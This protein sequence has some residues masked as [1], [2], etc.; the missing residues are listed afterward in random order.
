MLT[1]HRNIQRAKVYSEGKISELRVALLGI[2]LPSGVTIVSVGSVARR[3]ASEQSDLDYFVITESDDDSSDAWEKVGGLITAL[4]LRAPSPTGAFAKSVSTKKFLEAIGGGDESNEELTRRMLFLLESEWLFGEATYESL[5]D[6]VI[7]CY[8]K[9]KITQH[10][11]ARFFLNDLIRYYRTICVDFEYKTV[12]GGKSW[13]DRNIKLM[14]ARKL[15][16]FSGVISAAETVQSNCG[17]KRRELKRLL[18]KTP[19]E[20]VLDVCGSDAERALKRYDEFLGWLADGTAR[21]LL[22]GTTAN[23]ETHTNEFREMKNSGHHF[24]WELESLL[25]RRYAAT[26]PIYQA[27]LL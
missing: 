7:E 3:E 9:D 18:R 16:Y 27:I 2:G 10:Q 21:E 14:F 23:R 26:H 4:G 13:G 19:L 8:I 15:L 20:R 17:F 24:S 6:K 12:T 25:H 5:V 1:E 11:L 22:T